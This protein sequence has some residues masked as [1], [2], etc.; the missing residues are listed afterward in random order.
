MCKVDSLAMCG[1]SL[2]HNFNQKGVDI[3]LMVDRQKNELKW[4]E[5]HEGMLGM[6]RIPLSNINSKNMEICSLFNI[7]YDEH[8]LLFVVVRNNIFSESVQLRDQQ[9]PYIIFTYVIHEEH[10]VYSDDELESGHVENGEVSIDLSYV[11]VQE[12]GLDYRPLSITYVHHYDDE[13]NYVDSQQKDCAVPLVLISGSDYVLHTYEIDPST[14]RIHRGGNPQRRERFRIYW[15]ARLGFGRRDLIAHTQKTSISLPLFLLLEQSEKKLT[16]NHNKSMSV[17]QNQ[18]VAGY[19]S[20]LLVWNHCSAKRNLSV[21]PIDTTH[22]RT[23]GDFTST[24]DKQIESPPNNDDSDSCSVL[25]S[26][27]SNAQ[28]MEEER[29]TEKNSLDLYAK[30]KATESEAAGIEKS[31]ST[32]EVGIEGEGIDGDVPADHKNGKKL[33]KNVEEGVNEGF[34]IEENKKKKQAIKN[35]DDDDDDGGGDDNDGDDYDDEDEEDD[36][37]S[38]DFFDS[39]VLVSV[40]GN[41]S[42]IS[43]ESSLERQGGAMSVIK[44]DS[45]KRSEIEDSVAQG[46]P[47]EDREI[48][49]DE[50]RG[51]K[52]IDIDEHEH[53]SGRALVMRSAVTCVAFLSA[54]H[55]TENSKNSKTT[56]EYGNAELHS[57]LVVG[58]AQGAAIIPLD[59]ISQSPINGEE[60]DG[61]QTEHRSTSS[62]ELQSP[63]TLLPGLNKYGLVRAVQ[64]SD[65]TGDGYD[66]ILLGFQDG[67]VILLARDFDEERQLQENMRKRVLFATAQAHLKDNKHEDGTSSPNFRHQYQ[68]T[69][70]NSSTF[71]RPTLVFTERW[72]ASLPFP[73]CGLAYSCHVQPSYVIEPNSKMSKTLSILT[74]KTHHILIKT[75]TKQKKNEETCKSSI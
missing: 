10:V 41:S 70:A 22:L 46:N 51:E 67:T 42:S 47:E 61:N 24:I 7:S 66:D 36:D 15:E 54:S 17:Y 68:N 16:N 58:L 30:A 48:I 63:Q 31:L 21:A 43:I 35:D 55:K 52:K 18:C 4:S 69:S 20:G 32:R 37:E 26:S 25:N 64:V 2:V 56:T 34:K 75:K 38:R 6:R 9:K 72:S 33:H 59:S 40:S 28:N 53:F 29:S 73:I 71:L 23:G 65:V 57:H 1:S 60:K 11:A 14:L 50:D 13:D 39:G 19:S 62:D 3:F 27:F 5:V 44:E 49:D 8:S 74:T 45:T 12:L